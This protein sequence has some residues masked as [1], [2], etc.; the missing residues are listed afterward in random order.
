MKAT[1]ALPAEKQI[2][3]VSKKL[4]ELNPGFD[5]KLAGP[6]GGPAPK[7]QNGVVTGL[8]IHSNDIAD[9]SPL[10]ALVGLGYL[11]CGW[12]REEGQAVRFVSARRAAAD[13]T[14]ISGYASDRSISVEEH[15]PHALCR[16]SHPLIRS[17]AAQGHQADEDDLYGTKVSDLSPL[18]GM[19]LTNLNCTGTPISTSR[20]C[21]G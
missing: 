15:G 18:A 14:G 7:I 13:A 19:P 16:H 12:F 21:K 2:E 10:R 3:A 17:V 8:G 1:Q 6:G 4:M 5:G 9:I 11:T 20:P